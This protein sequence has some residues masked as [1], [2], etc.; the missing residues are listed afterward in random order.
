[1]NDAGGMV[2][3]TKELTRIVSFE[4]KF[5]LITKYKNKEHEFNSDPIRHLIKSCEDE[6]RRSIKTIRSKKKKATW[7]NSDFFHQHKRWNNR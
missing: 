7:L 2:T 3:K 4:L 1:M 6:A 5:K